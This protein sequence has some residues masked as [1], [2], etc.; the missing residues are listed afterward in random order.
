MRGKEDQAAK[1]LSDR[2]EPQ[3]RRTF[4]KYGRVPSVAFVVSDEQLAVM[5]LPDGEAVRG[6][7]ERI[8][9]VAA[10]MDAY[11][12]ALVSEEVAKVVDGAGLEA[13]KARTVLVLFQMDR[14][15]PQ[16]R[17]AAVDVTGELGE[18]QDFAIRVDGGAAEARPASGHRGKR[19]V[20]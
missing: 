1:V 20:S 14:G 18:F 12:V 9:A 13:G 4:N 11:L 8:K 16:A 10:V 19:W 15:E 17:I 2:I 5:P 7:L 3:V 6:A